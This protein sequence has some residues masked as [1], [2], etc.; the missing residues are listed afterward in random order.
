MPASSLRS[1]GVLTDLRRLRPELPASVRKVADTVLADPAGAVAGTLQELAATSGTSPSAVSRLCRRLGVDGYPALRLSVI[2]DAAA[3]TGSPWELDISRTI[4]PTDPLEDVARTLGAAQTYAVMDTLAGLDLDAVRA[5]ADAIAAARRVQLYAVSGSAVM[6]MELQLRLHRIGV[7]TWSF[8]DVHEGLTGAA[9]LEPGDVAIAVSFTGETV[10]TVEMLRTAA[11]RGA[12]TAA[13]TG[14]AESTLARAADHVLVTVTEET[15]F[16]EG[17]LAARFSELTVV[18]LL[19]LAVSQASVA[20][21]TEL[22]DRTAHA[23]RSH[24][25]R[26]PA[27]R[28]GRA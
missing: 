15:T 20:R 7:P 14:G 13:V 17:P 10:E 23:V 12:L 4:S 8:T 24:Q 2:A 1:S 21:T 5:L 19:Y 27:P 16:R 18:E 11:E 28:P 9:L 26:R 22:L 25:R 6:T 3:G